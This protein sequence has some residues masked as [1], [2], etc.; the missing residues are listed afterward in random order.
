MLHERRGSAL[1]A[2]AFLAL[3]CSPVTLAIE[4]KTNLLLHVDDGRGTAVSYAAFAATA[5]QG[6]HQAFSCAVGDRG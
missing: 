3:F 1:D 4:T 5:S 2:S 6:S